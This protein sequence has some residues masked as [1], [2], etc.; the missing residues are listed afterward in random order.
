[1]SCKNNWF[2]RYLRCSY[3][4]KSHFLSRPNKQYI[5]VFVTNCHL[6]SLESKDKQVSYICNV[7]LSN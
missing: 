7:I 3:S 6:K 4:H 2:R 1:M 5:S